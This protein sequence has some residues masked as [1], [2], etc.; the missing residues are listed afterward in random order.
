MRS[1]S[2][3]ACEGE[4]DFPDF[5]KRRPRPCDSRQLGH[6][7][8]QGAAEADS[9]PAPGAL[10]SLLPDTSGLRATCSVVYSPYAT[11]S[12]LQTRSHFYT[13]WYLRG[14]KQQ[15]IITAA[16]FGRWP[17]PH[18]SCL[19]KG[20]ISPGPPPFSLRKVLWSPLHGP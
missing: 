4:A 9:C 20:R 2:Q 1:F 10:S 6:V 18:A 11:V 13:P 14:V 16:A 19:L 15:L 7:T 17:L 12:S 8:S 3:Q 5:Q